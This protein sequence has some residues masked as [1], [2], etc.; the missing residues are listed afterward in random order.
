MSV[1]RMWGKEGVV[2]W[3]VEMMMEDWGW[4]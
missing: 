1:G 3:K 4:R 2:W